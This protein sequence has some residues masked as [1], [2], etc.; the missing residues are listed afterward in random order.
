MKHIVVLTGAGISANSGIA[1]FRDSDGLWANHNIAD[2]C[3]PE[4][5]VNNRSVVI[6]F[7]ND[8]RRE[9]IK[10]KPNAG[11]F[12]LNA[13]Y[14]GNQVDIITQNIDDLHERAGNKHVLHLHGEIRMLRSSKDP[15]A[16][17]PIEGVEQD[18]TS[19][20]PDGS[21]LRPHVVFFGEPVPNFERAAK[22][23]RT[24]DVLLIVGTSLV[25]YPAAS[26]VMD[27]KPGVPVI[28]VDPKKPEVSHI[29]NPY[30]Y[31][32][33]QAQDGVKEAVDYILNLK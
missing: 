22:I 9:V 16:L 6:K 15:N 12:D 32:Q 4:A 2:V 5:L 33:A 10:A 7:Y 20:H 3:T 8:R 14:D 27:L 26:L 29:P 25:V 30:K 1:T 11:H 18:E 24:A 31:I 28:I 13:L 19:R 17:V 21:L 23:V